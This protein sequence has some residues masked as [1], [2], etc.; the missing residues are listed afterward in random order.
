MKTLANSHYAKDAIKLLGAYEE[1]SKTTTTPA[2]PAREDPKARL[3]RSVSPT[4]GR[5]VTTRAEETE[6]E[7]AAKSFARVRGGR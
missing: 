3:E 6:A 1:Y 5:T 7:A 2:Q 4:Q